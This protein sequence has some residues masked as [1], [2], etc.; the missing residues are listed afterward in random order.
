MQITFFI[1]RGLKPVRWTQSPA[2]YHVAIKAS[3]Y[4]KAV[5]AS[6]IPIPYDK[7]MIVY[8]VMKLWLSPVQLGYVSNHSQLKR[9]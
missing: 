7:Y 8:Y 2:L 6:Y 9:V 3:L 1:H 4:H 5:K